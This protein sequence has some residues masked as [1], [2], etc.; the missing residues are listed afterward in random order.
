MNVS[1]RKIWLSS[2][3]MHGEEMGR[4]DDERKYKVSI[5]MPAYN[6]EKYIEKAIRSAM[7]QTITDL[8]IIVVD[9]N[10]KDNTCKIVEALAAEDQRIRLIKCKENMG[11]AKARNLAWDACRGKYVALLDCDDIWYPQKLEKQIAI[12]QKENAD[13]VYCSY[14]IID[15]AGAK[16]CNDFIVPESTTFES[17]L[18]R[19]VI[20]C[21]TALLS[22]R[23]TRNYRFP[24]GY[25]HEDLALWLKLL[26]DG[27][28][29]V[30]I[31][32]VLA[33]YRVRS[34]S[35]ASNKIAVAIKRWKIYRSM[36]KFSVAKSAYYFIQYAFAGLIKYRNR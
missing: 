1:D 27:M 34:N 21:S 10:S 25:Y 6:A 30:G 18:S 28:K 19:S 7:T 3:T 14:A 11:A 33:E 20:S 17:A 23:V 22:P 29:A 24:I 2:P 8:E 35:R 5:I 9:D 32:E 26:G 36:M 13:I 15:E 16:K 31:P 4:L 12:A